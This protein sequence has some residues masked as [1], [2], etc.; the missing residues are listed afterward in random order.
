MHTPAEGADCTLL[1]E[2]TFPLFSLGFLGAHHITCKELMER[3]FCQS[4]RFLLFLYAA[5]LPWKLRELGPNMP[6]H[7]NSSIIYKGVGER[8][9]KLVKFAI[10][11]RSALL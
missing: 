11:V 10:D 5:Y 6:Q 4:H 7:A 2:E 9:P 3:P 1:E 8:S